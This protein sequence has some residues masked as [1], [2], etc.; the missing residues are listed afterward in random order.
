[1]PSD[2]ASTL[3]QRIQALLEDRQ[4]HAD[5]MAQIDETLAQ[6][7]S[8]LNGSPNVQRHGP[9]PGRPAAAPAIPVAAPKKRRRGRG[10]FSTTAEEFVLSFVQSNKSP[11]SREINEAWT[12]EGR[13]YKADNTLTKLVKEKKLKRVP[14]GEGIRGSRYSI[15]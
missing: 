15:A 8:A 3:P 9:Q 13:G 12:A 1:M 4:R 11:T 14:L 7:G 10:G 2:S 6:I 5:A